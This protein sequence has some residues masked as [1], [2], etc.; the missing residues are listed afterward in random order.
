MP[1]T[2][3]VLSPV[4]EVTKVID[5]A[6]IARIIVCFKIR[7]ENLMQKPANKRNV[8]QIENC[9]NEAKFV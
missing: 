4:I 7:E 5:I 3:N 8:P 6:H 1:K 9:Q 2:I